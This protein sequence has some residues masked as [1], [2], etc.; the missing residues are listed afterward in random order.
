MATTGSA[1]DDAVVSVGKTFFPDP[2]AFSLSSVVS[3]APLRI[4]PAFGRVDPGRPQKAAHR[5][6]LVPPPE[7]PAVSYGNTHNDDRRYHGRLSVMEL[8]NDEASEQRTV[9]RTTTRPVAAPVVYSRPLHRGKHHS[10]HSGAAVVPVY[11]GTPSRPGGQVQ[12][13]TAKTVFQ[14]EQAHFFNRPRGRWRHVEEQCNHQQPHHHPLPPHPHTRLWPAL[15]KDVASMALVMLIDGY[16]HL[17]QIDPLDMQ[18]AEVRYYANIAASDFDIL[19]GAVTL[20]KHYTEDTVFEYPNKTVSSSFRYLDHPLVAHIVPYIRRPSR[21]RTVSPEYLA[22]IVRRALPIF[23]RNPFKNYTRVTKSPLLDQFIS[24][25]YG[26]VKLLP[27]DLAVK[28]NQ[29][30]LPDRHATNIQLPVNFELPTFPSL[31][32]NTPLETYEYSDDERLAMSH[33]N[34]PAFKYIFPFWRRNHQGD[35]PRS[36]SCPPCTIQIRDFRFLHWIIGVRGVAPSTTF[37]PIVAAAIRNTALAAKMFPQDAET[38]SWL[39]ELPKFPEDQELEFP[40]LAFPPNESVGFP[41]K[42]QPSPSDPSP[43]ESTSSM[44]KPR[45]RGSSSGLFHHE[46]LQAPHPS[47]VHTVGEDPNRGV[48]I[49]P[50]SLSESYVKDAPNNAS[51]PPVLDENDDVPES[52]GAPIRCASQDAISGQNEPDNASPI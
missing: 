51:P 24:A 45:S 13:D 17:A 42:W 6:L 35:G 41:P 48:M 46:A 22:A 28:L 20:T 15:E 39:D 2:L 11:G 7:Q 30:I 43:S 18:S 27:V 4:S 31:P 47:S 40:A 52:I 32:R 12:V 37:V 21:R 34:D 29:L 26:L 50:N 3:A 14:S 44:F 10:F 16:L 25:L 8:C 9:H 1:Y 19:P 33:F 5:A 38:Q 49:K 23:V 36:Y